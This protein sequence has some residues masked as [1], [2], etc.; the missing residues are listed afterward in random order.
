MNRRNQISDL[1]T[2]GLGLF[3]ATWFLPLIFNSL[4]FGILCILGVVW[5]Y[6][7]KLEVR[8]ELLI[9]FIVWVVALFLS[10]LYNSNLI[11]EELY[12]RLAPIGF[13]YFAFAPITFFDGKK[14][15][16]IGSWF[17]NALIFVGGLMILI[18]GIE[19][20]QNASVYTIPNTSHIYYNRFIYHNLSAPLGFNAIRMALVF[21]VG[22]LVHLVFKNNTKNKVAWWVKFSALIGVILLL[23]S[24]VAIFFNM[25]LMLY[26]F[27]PRVSNSIKW[28][29]GTIIALLGLFILINKIDPS[30]IL[31]EW[32]QPPQYFGSL[33]IRYALA[34]CGIEAFLS[35]NPTVGI[36]FSAVKH[37]LLNIYKT[38]G[39]NLAVE[40]GYYLH[41]Q[42]LTFLVASGWAG[43]LSFVF[44]LYSFGKNILKTRNFY[45]SLLYLFLLF[46]LF[47]DDFLLI[48]R[49][50]MFFSAVLYIVYFLSLKEGGKLVVSNKRVI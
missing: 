15:C 32:D 30:N 3:G 14:K 18:A 10:D 2:I 22:M 1:Y 13:G 16:F 38:H 33:S 24:S 26:Y 12:L 43:L 8:Y 28:I 40:N 49:G 34:I 35:G 41:N 46:E 21:S 47:W 27:A 25:V 50:G 20:F 45:Y 19:S 48:Q 29:G 37:V 6:Q 42:Y 23:R 4:A 5:M 39:F 17:V 11:N 31:F 7:N 44:I 9:A 36:G